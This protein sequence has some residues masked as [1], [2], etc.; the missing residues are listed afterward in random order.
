MPCQISSRHAIRQ[1]ILDIFLTLHL[2]SEILNDRR[3]IT[4]QWNWLLQIQDRPTLTPALESSILALGLG[5][6][7]R[8]YDNEAHVLEGL[9]MYTRELRQLRQALCNPKAQ[10]HKDPRHLYGIDYF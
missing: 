6:L 4:K 5:K 1:Q 10:F 3:P 2:P 9:S 7:G 8:K